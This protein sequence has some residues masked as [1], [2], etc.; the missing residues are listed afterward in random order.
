M[1]WLWIF[2]E[3]V[4]LN[5]DPRGTDKGVLWWG[6]WSYLI[7][8][9]TRWDKRAWILEKP[10]I[11]P[12]PTSHDQAQNP[13]ILE[14]IIFLLSSR[15]NRKPPGLSNNPRPLQRP[16]L[17]SGMVSLTKSPRRQLKGRPC[18][19]LSVSGSSTVSGFLLR[20]R[21]RAVG[22]RG[23]GSWSLILVATNS[24]WLQ[25]TL[26]AH[27]QLSPLLLS[28]ASQERLWVMC[29]VACLFQ[30]RVSLCS[31]GCPKIHM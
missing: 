6:S 27:S 29:F 22:T 2:R 15:R 4:L 31:F 25:G 11:P 3:L 8:Q 23:R 24:K 28:T 14:N 1:C 18:V 9:C 30:D 17:T 19:S 10:F 12:P 20:Q 26:V 13:G 21:I 7:T 16:Y 5:W